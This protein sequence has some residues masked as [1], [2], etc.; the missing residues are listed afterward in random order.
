MTTRRG[1]VESAAGGPSRSQWEV[2][3]DGINE[4]ITT[5]ALTPGS[6]L[7]VE[8]DLAE[9]LGVSRSSLREGVRALALMGVLE[10]RQ[11]AGTY[12]TALD[13]A[14]LLAPL[15]VLV[16]LQRPGNIADVM[17]V[18]RIL[19]VEAAA[20]A[21]TRISDAELTAAGD[22]LTQMEQMLSQENIAHDAVMDADVDFHRVIAQASGNPTLSAFINGLASRTV[23]ARLWR[24]LQQEGVER[25]TQA[26]HASILTALTARDPDAAR[27]RMSVHLLNVEQ[28]LMAQLEADTGWGT[29]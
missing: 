21:A 3:L 9:Q 5:G 14:S 16:N 27:L 4:M 23:R 20:R 22:I 29:G 11:G 7:P 19:E 15:G 13:P 6:R 12:V 26:E 1:K 2:V 18:R 28:Y 8:K 24:A 17:L 25:Q 10:T